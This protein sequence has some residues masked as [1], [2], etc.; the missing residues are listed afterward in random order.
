M[1]T[2]LYNDLNAQLPPPVYSLKLSHFL[3]ISIMCIELVNYVHK[4][5]LFS[6]SYSNLYFY[7][8]CSLATR[9]VV[10]MTLMDVKFN[11]E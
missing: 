5:M 11:A 4:L 6:Y 1:G 3:Y 8:C 9:Q 10:S 7:S 2:Y